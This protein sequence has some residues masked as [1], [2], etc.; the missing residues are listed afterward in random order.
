MS[1]TWETT[2]DD[3]LNV[4]HKMGRKAT[5]DQVE[6][7]FDSLDHFN[8]EAAA[9]QANDLNAQTDLAY[10]E[11][12]RQIKCLDTCGKEIAASPVQSETEQKIYTIPEYGITV[13][14]TPGKAGE[15]TSGLAEALIGSEPSESD[16]EIQGAIA[17]LE[18][19][20]LG[21]ACAGIDIG[22]EAYV[23]GLRSCL[24]AISNNL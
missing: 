11:I 1:N 22:S 17:A 13:H 21:H 20:I 2:I 18:S 10:A 9:L 8:I 5:S 15:I 16:F 4:I 19:L 6:T 7:I 12:E 14:V 3:V 24:E 23:T